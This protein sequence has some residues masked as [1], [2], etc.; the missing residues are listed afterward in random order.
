[1]LVENQRIK[2][3]WHY[4]NKSHFESKGYKFT[5]INDVFVVN[6]NDLT[7]SS[8]TRVKIKCDYCGR[9]YECYYYSYVKSHAIL[10]K[11]A[12]KHCALCCSNQ[13]Q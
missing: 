7:N 3:R 4:K 10:N 5:N 13:Q 12:C 8:S 2:M 1:M 9:E 6:I 11:D